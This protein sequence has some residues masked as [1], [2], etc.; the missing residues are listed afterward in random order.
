VITAKA[1]TYAL[2]GALALWVSLASTVLASSDAVAATTTGLGY[3]PLGSPARIADTRSGA[4]D[5]STYAGRTLAPGA[6]LTVDVPGVPSGTGAIVAQL[7]AVAPTLS[8]YLSAYPAGSSAPGTANVVFTSGQTVGN[9]VTVGVGTDPSTGSPAVTVSN[10]PSGST[11]FTLDLYG[12]YAPQTSSSGDAYVPLTPARI[13]DT[14][15]Q[16]GPLGPGGTVSV[17][18]AGA[19]GVPIGAGAVVLNVAV[20]DTTASSFIECYPT[21]S[22]PSGST[23]TVDENWV[24]G[25]TLSTQVILAVGSSGSVTCENAA[26]DADLVADAEGYYTGAGGSGSLLTP[27]ASP[28][29]LV[30]T[31]PTAEAPGS[32]LVVNV[33]GSAGVPS[34]ASAGVFDITDI[35]AGPNYLTAYPNGSAVPTTASV[36]YVPGDTSSTLSNSAYATVGN[37]GVVDVYDSASPANIVVDEF[38]YFTPPVASAPS[39][40]VV[41]TTQLPTGTVGTSY[42]ANLSASGGTP[43]YAWALSAGSLPGGLSLSASGAITGTPTTSGTAGFTVRVT[44][45]TLP[46]PGT[47]TAA[48]S[49]TVAAQQTPP[50]QTQTV[51]SPNWSGYIVTPGT[52]TEV[53]GTFTVPSLS[54]Y[55]PNS[56][57]TEWVGIDGF[58]S[59]NDSLIQAGVDEIPVDST[60][61]AVQPWWEILPAPQT[62]ITSM[63]VGVGDSMTVTIQ[64]LSAS[65]WSIT[66]KDDTN[67]ESFVT[68][69]TYDGPLTSAEWIVEAPTQNNS[70]SPLA[71]YSPEVSFS[72]LTVIGSET[73]LTKVLLIQ[74][75]Q[76]LSTP[77]A[78]TSSGFNVAYG[79][80]TPAAPQLRFGSQIGPGAGG[81]L[82]GVPG[83][84]GYSFPPMYGAGVG[85]RSRASPVS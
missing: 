54:S 48:L 62:N 34:N 39:P 55:V 21:G 85:H 50:P 61:F 4:S 44:D 57:T 9:L 1:A 7:T 17:P 26:G 41:T 78:F 67:G 29:R 37:G 56:A 83:S 76:Q 28:V 69:Q 77:S 27:L 31:R 58:P 24:A 51:E 6:S 35:A 11:N 82:V 14:R 16:G 81:G 64:Q 32:S 45:S 18:V 8:G 13:F 65:E 23:P 46:V 20:T 5:P 66:V 70:V 52:Y 15:S 80:A 71:P 19:G 60:H 3:V 40:L 43:P 42:S 79:S 38:A 72:D 49:I 25:E 63:T 2:A 30:D 68:D 74:N 33:A 10:G 53:S 12:Y 22:P 75:N 73:T 59:G 84:A 36:N 47:A